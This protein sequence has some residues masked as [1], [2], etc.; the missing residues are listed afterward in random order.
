MDEVVR[1]L[2]RLRNAGLLTALSF[3]LF[4]SFFLPSYY[5]PSERWKWWEIFMTLLNLSLVIAAVAWIYKV[6]G[7]WS[8]CR[9]KMRKLYCIT[10]YIHLW[11]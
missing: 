5:I 9:S 3:L 1:G 7:W 6:L 4:L 11:V 10:K 8:M 2:S